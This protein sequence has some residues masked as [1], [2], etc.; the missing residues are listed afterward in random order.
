MLASV[1]LH[2]LAWM[3]RPDDGPVAV[4]LGLVLACGLLGRALRARA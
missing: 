2:W 3:T 1:L 4:L